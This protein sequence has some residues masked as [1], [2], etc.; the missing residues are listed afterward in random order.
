MIGISC[1]VSL[2]HTAGFLLRILNPKMIHCFTIELTDKR[3]KAAVDRL[4]PV[5]GIKS[6]VTDP[7]LRIH[8]HLT[9]EDKSIIRTDPYGIYSPYWTRNQ[10]NAYQFKEG[11]LIIDF[12]DARTN[13]W[14]WRGWAISIL[15]GDDVA[16]TEEKINVAVTKILNEFPPVKNK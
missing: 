11:T 10:I 6:S 3:I 2:K 14:V 1:L 12:M 5:R 13:A 15:E 16:L 9:I 7:D 4:M 8:Y